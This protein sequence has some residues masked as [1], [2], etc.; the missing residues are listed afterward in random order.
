MR[1]LADFGQIWLVDF[2]FHAPDGERPRP[3]CVVGHELRSR[4]T[5]RRWLDGELLVAHPPYTCDRSSLFVA[6]Y[7]SAEWG[8]HLALGWPLPHYV[9][10]LFCE[11]RCLTNGRTLPLGASLLGALS[12]YGL[13]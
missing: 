5:V 9:L 11:F 12:W 7:S 2:E 6:F 1:T 10:D 13:D 4:L 8:C 3:L